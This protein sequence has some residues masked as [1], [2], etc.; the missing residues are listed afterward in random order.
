MDVTDEL[1]EVDTIR[2]AR[3]KQ[4]LSSSEVFLRRDTDAT[5]SRKL[6]YAWLSKERL[7]EIPDV[8]RDSCMQ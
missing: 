7:R 3:R 6:T 2:R 5:L 4:Q 8:K 1:K